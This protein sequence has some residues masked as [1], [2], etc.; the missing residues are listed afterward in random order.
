[1]AAF[2]AT[3]TL[4]RANWFTD[5]FPSCE[6]TVAHIARE[7]RMNEEFQTMLAT[8]PTTKYE[9][10]RNARQVYGDGN[11]EQLAVLGFQLRKE[12]DTKN[13]EQQLIEE[14]RR[15]VNLPD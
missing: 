5:I 8:L 11:P 7:K 4:A 15:L 13:H 1:M 10:I 9:D 6:G 3:T 12:A 14:A 2:V